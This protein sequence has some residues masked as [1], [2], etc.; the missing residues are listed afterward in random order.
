MSAQEN[1]NQACER[2]NSQ[3]ENSDC[4][5]ANHKTFPAIFAP[6]PCSDGPPRNAI[7]LQ[8]IEFES[9][10][11]RLIGSACL[12]KQRLHL[13]KRVSLDAF[14][15]LTFGLCVALYCHAFAELDWPPVELFG[16]LVVASMFL[17]GR[18]VGKKPG[19]S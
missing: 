8:R 18:V 2:Q 13:A 4:E 14:P 17:G 5:E 11:R 12:H 3:H 7:R 6:R 1:N 15:T 9:Q 10:E 16:R 19:V